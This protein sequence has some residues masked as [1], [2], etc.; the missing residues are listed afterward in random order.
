MAIYDEYSGF[1]NLGGLQIQG[2]AEMVQEGTDEYFEVM[3]YKKLPHDAFD[4]MERS[5]HLIKV[6][7]QSMDY[8]NSDLKKLGYESR[9]HLEL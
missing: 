8:L 5:M 4:K 9:Q 1:G 3:D 2:T 6:T 7:P